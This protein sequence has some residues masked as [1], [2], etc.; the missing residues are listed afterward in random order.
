M[1]YTQLQLDE[2]KLS[3]YAYSLTKVIAKVPT[4]GFSSVRTL[5]GAKVFCFFFLT[6]K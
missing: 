5:I 4:E 1:Y 6:V 2:N 3:T